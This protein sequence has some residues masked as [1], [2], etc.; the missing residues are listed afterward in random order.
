MDKEQFWE[1]L[2]I[3]HRDVYAYAGEIVTCPNGHAIFGLTKTVMRNDILADS[4][5]WYQTQPPTGAVICNCERCGEK[6]FD[7]TI[8][9][10]F[11]FGSNE[12]RY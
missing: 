6:W 2:T 8:G 10:K 1:A 9:H 12:I 5:V 11:F 4:H 3:D 7:A